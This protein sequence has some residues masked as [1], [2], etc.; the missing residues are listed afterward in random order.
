MAN[1]I[2]ILAA[3]LG[4]N[5][6]KNK[7]KCVTAESCTGGGISYWI[8]SVPNSSQWFDRGFVTYTNISKQ[9]LINVKKLTLDEFGAVSENTAHE[10]AIGA[11]KNSN[12]DLSVAVTGVAGPGGGTIKKPIGTVFIATSRKN[13]KTNV[14]KFNFSGSRSSI[15]E[16]TIITA[17]K[18]LIYTI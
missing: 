2:E 8:T 13:N 5:L 1:K 16:Q 10:M 14:K 4:K 9:E 12:G 15:R 11:L 7:L 18:Q 3:E 17:L 6:I